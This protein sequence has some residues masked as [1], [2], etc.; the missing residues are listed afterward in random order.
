[1]VH[2][3]R[4]QTFLTIYPISNGYD[5]PDQVPSL[6]LVLPFQVRR[7]G[8]RNAVYVFDYS[9]HKAHLSGRCTGEPQSGY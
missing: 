9:C 7:R 2:E 8:L 3:L 1:M 5:D 6:V 4:K